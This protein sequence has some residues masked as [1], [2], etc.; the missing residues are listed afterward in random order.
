MISRVKI[1]RRRLL[2]TGAALGAGLVSGL[3]PLAAGAQVTS[4]A[5][6]QPND[7]ESDRIAA[8]FLQGAVPAPQGLA[9]DLPALGDNP[10]AV[11]VRVHLTEPVSETSFC[12]ELIVLARR[13]PRPLIC[14]FRFSPLTGAADV[15]LRVRLME[16]ME[17]HAI[18]RMND[19]RFLEARA[20][21]T[22]AAGGCGM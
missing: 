18:A 10:A 12:E 8:E 14:R 7:G 16:S 3:L 1:D 2:T 21:I 5:M 11:P 6:P 15:A 9:L 4:T 19:G 13:N 20:D 22:V 17:L